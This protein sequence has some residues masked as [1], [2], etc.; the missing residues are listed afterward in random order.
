MAWSFFPNFSHRP[1]EDDTLTCEAQRGNFI[2]EISER[3]NVES[4]SNVEVRCEV[5]AQNSAGTRILE[6]I[7]EGS[8]VQK[9]DLLCKLDDS[10]LKIDAM[11]QQSAFHTSEA[12]LIQA[13]NEHE[14][15]KIALDEYRLGKL[16]LEKEQAESDIFKAEEA[17]KRSKDYARHSEKLEARGYISKVT[18]QADLMLEKQAQ[19]D[20]KVATTKKLVLLDYTSKKMEKQLDSDIRTTK[21]KSAAQEATHSL[22]KDRL[23]QIKAQIDKC[24]IRAPEPGQVVYANNNEQRYGGQETIIEE[25][26]TVRERQVL[27]KLP[28]PK[29]MQV[30]AKVNESKIALVREKQTVL[31]RLDA[32]PDLE[33]TGVVQKVNEYPAASSWWGSNIKEYETVIA[34]QDSPVALKPGLTAEVRICVASQ[35]DVVT[36]PV[37][38]VLE[39]GGKHYCM[40]STAAGWEPHEVT[41]GLSNDSRVVIREGLE[42]GDMV[43]RSASSLREQ[44]TL[45]ELPADTPR[46]LAAGSKTAGE[47]GKAGPGG[48]TP[49]KTAAKAPTAPA[50]KIDRQ[51]PAA[52]AKPTPA[53]KPSSAAAGGRT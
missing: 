29:R 48:K 38:S 19:E 42:P 33:L 8:Y 45:P 22:D 3:G 21:A 25:G 16:R 40:R 27:F 14:I 5:Q 18:M 47:A 36:V 53:V 28:D 12:A 49:G 43:A 31:I 10:A 37:L 11:K 4:A 24:T 23:A 44:V 46:P 51:P 52:G 50:G 15:A 9:G 26:A 39:H 1:E 20:S 2:H 13:Q 32:F 35:L 6:V 41:I 7:P 30:K 17:V 34:I